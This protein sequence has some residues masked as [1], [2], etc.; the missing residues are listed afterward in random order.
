MLNHEHFRELCALAA[1]GQLTSDEDRELTQHLFECESCRTASLEYAHVVQHQLPKSDPIRWRIKGLLPNTAPDFEVRERFLARALTEGVEFS[2]EVSRTSGTAPVKPLDGTRSWPNVWAVAAVAAIAVLGAGFYRIGVHRGSMQGTVKTQEA[3]AAE[4][5]ALT[6]QLQQIREHADSLSAELKKVQATDSIDADSLQHITSRLAL[7][8]E[9][10]E[11]L[12]AELQASE[13]KKAELAKTGQQKDALI[14]DLNGRNN[15]L[16]REDA[17]NL[18]A[19]VVLESQV[20]ELDQ[21]IEQQASSFE[22]ERELM[23]ASKDVR[24]LMGARNLHILD[25]HDTDGEGRSA[26]AFGRVFYAEGQS[27]IFYAFDLPSGKL[28][29]AKYSFQAWGEKESVSHS[30]R[31][32]G[33]FVVDDHEQRR[34][35]LKVTEPKLLKDIDSVF[36]TAESFTDAP[37]PH[38]KKLLYAY[39]V[40]QPNHP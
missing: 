40:G 4:N 5:K 25:V 13:A 11:S 10:S 17:D 6:Q 23:M 32:L 37:E 26:K 33:T 29:P 24:Q 19:R 8:R 34:W 9:Q 30:V 15:K 3:L 38:G 31:N 16:A 28:T 22:Q 12:S 14:S 36:V 21:R 27:L 7:A 1:I 18:S 39:I 20:R 2:P 35:V